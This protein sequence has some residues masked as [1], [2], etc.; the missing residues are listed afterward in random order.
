MKFDDVVKAVGNQLDLRRIASAYVKDHRR[1]TDDEL[2]LAVQEMK[3]QYLS[4]EKIE[5]ALERC[6]FRDPRTD[7]RVLSRLL[8]VDVL[9]DRYE[10]TLTYAQTEEGVI[11]FEQSILDRSNEVGLLDLASGN[12]DSQRYKNIE[13]YDFVLR[14]AWENDN[15]KSPDEVNLLRRLR[16]RLNVTESDHRLLEAKLSKYP[17]ESNSQHTRSEIN[18]VRR[19]LQGLGLLMEVRQEDGPS[20]DIIPEELAAKIRKILGLELRSDSYK[21]LMS[22][23]RLR[24]KA[25][26]TEVLTRNEIDFGKYD[27]IDK[28]VTRLLSY[29]PPSKAI[30]SSS[31]RYGLNSEQLAA[32]CR[33]LK[34][35]R[36]GTI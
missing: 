13:L 6:L 27:S 8:L 34:M 14:V 3:G 29:V 36:S 5:L 18:E 32:W 16:E 12:K 26:L 1:L 17:K 20:F 21:D 25:H 7:Y 2:R 15:T 33:D 11:A 35:S 23:S 30:A 22:Y 19:Y 4:E 10:F 28:L 24:R 9:L 31:P